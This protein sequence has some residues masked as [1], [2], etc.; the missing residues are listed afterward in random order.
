MFCV[1]DEAHDSAEISNEEEFGHGFTAA[2][3][4]MLH[5]LR[6][7]DSFLLTDHTMHLLRVQASTRSAYTLKFASAEC[8]NK[9]EAAMHAEDHNVED[10][11]YLPDEVSYFVDN[12]NNAKV[13]YEELF[14]FF[15][16]EFGPVQEPPTTTG[17]KSKLVV[18]HPPRN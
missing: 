18:F 6:Q 15:E 10:D 11:G 7:K 13:L 2:G 12:A 17:K 9:L 16:G 4:L 14:N 8:D 5:L 1:E 3:A